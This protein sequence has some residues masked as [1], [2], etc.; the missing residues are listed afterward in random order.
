MCPLASKLSGRVA[1]NAGASSGESSLKCVWSSVCLFIFLIFR[2]FFFWWI[3]IRLALRVHWA[4]FDILRRCGETSSRPDSG[5]ADSFLGPLRH[6][7]C[8]VLSSACF[9]LVVLRGASFEPVR[10][11]SG[12]ENPLPSFFFFCRCPVDC[13][14]LPG[15]PRS[16]FFEEHPIL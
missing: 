8:V 3:D 16:G 10:R 2:D 4:H 5:T 12:T 14:T 7:V 11:P 1:V 13:A 9:P 15:L 6:A